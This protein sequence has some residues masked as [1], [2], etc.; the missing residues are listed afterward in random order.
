VGGATSDAR[1]FPSRRGQSGSSSGVRRRF[2]SDAARK[3]RQ[4]RKEAVCSAPRACQKD[5]RGRRPRPPNSPVPH[6]RPRRPP[7]A[8]ARARGR[9]G[10]GAETRFSRR[11]VCRKPRREP[12]GGGVQRPVLFPDLER[13][14]SV[15]AHQPR[16]VAR[17]R[18]LLLR[19]RRGRARR[20]RRGRSKR[21]PLPERTAVGRARDEREKQTSGR[22]SAERVGGNR[23]R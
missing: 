10:A 1:T 19:R 8:R 23:R 20:G 7:A 12:L 17:H 11:R 3:P 6:A 14:E 15:R 5:A 2:L 9:H 4:K 16:V 18:L 21:G 13:R 22:V